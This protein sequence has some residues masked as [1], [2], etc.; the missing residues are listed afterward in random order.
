L[1]RQ[2]WG[3]TE[4]LHGVKPVSA[5]AKLRRERGLPTDDQY[6]ELCH[7]RRVLMAACAPAL[8]E[9]EGNPKYLHA[10]LELIERFLPQA[11]K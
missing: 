9:R 8:L 11:V 1:E 10:A 3:H 2:Y 6:A 5:L 7:A 4:L